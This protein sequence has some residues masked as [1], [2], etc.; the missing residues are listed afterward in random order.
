MNHMN[1]LVFN[2]RPTCKRLLL[3]FFVVYLSACA[4]D[5]QG[6]PQVFQDSS[7]PMLDLQNALNTAQNDGKLLALVLGAQWCHDSRGLAKNFATKELASL[8]ADNYHVIYLDVGY[9]KDLR[10]VTQRFGQAHYYATPTVMIIDPD[11]ETWLNWHDHEVW[12]NADSLPL[13]EYIRYFDKYNSTNKDKIPAIHSGVSKSHLADIQAFE[14]I[15]SDRLQNAYGIL[16]PDMLQEDSGDE[17]NALF[18]QR[19]NEVRSFRSQLNIDIRQ[20]YADAK[21][22][23]DTALTLPSYAPFEWEA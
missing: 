19:W 1:K 3:C 17:V 2:L 6:Y 13:S 16:V 18:Y 9:Y 5:E 14:K 23:P 21:E 20:L 15:Q 8:L 10:Q 22:K 11:S 4:N 12:G 7:T